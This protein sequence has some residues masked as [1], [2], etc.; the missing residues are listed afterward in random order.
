MKIDVDQD[1]NLRLQ[2]VFSGINMKAPG[3]NV[4]G[5]CMR[6]GTFEINVMP[7]GKHTGNWWRVDMESGRIEP[8]PTIAHQP[9]SES[10]SCEPS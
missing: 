6:D 2:E 5:V 10:D 9:V 1:R 7:R 3:G 8:M 4:I